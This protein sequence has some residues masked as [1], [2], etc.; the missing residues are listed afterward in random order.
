MQD[1]KTVGEAANEKKIV[2]PRKGV[3]FKSIPLISQELQEAINAIVID[4]GVPASMVSTASGQNQQEVNDFGGAKWWNKPLGYVAGAT[5][6]LENG[7]IVKSTVANNTIDPNVDMTGWEKLIRPVNM[8][9]VKDHGAIE[10]GVT[11]NASILQDYANII[12]TERKSYM[13]FP[14]YDESYLIDGTITFKYP[15]GI[16]GTKPASQTRNSVETGKKGN[17]LIG[18]NSDTVFDFGASLSKDDRGGYY[19]D[20]WTVKN[21]GFIQADGV[22]PRTKTCIKHTAATDG[23][24][25]FL[26]LREVSAM[27]VRHALHITNQNKSV[28]V[29]SMVVENCALSNNYIPLF[30]EGNVLGLRFVGNQCEQNYGGAIH[31]TF[32]SSVVIHDN[33]LE[34]QPNT[35]NI[36]VPPITGN[37]PKISIQ[38]NYFELNSGDYLINVNSNSSGGVI[39]VKNNYQ[40]LMQNVTDTLR[41]SGIYERFENHDFIPT[42]NL[43]LMKKAEG[44]ISPTNQFNIRVGGSN[45]DNASFYLTTKLDQ[46]KVDNSFSYATPS[47]PSLVVSTNQGDYRYIGMLASYQY[48]PINVEINDVVQ[49]D[50]AYVDHSATGGYGGAYA[51]VYT[52]DYSLALSQGTVFHERTQGDIEV[53]TMFFIVKKAT[54]ALRFRVENIGADTYL[55]GASAKIVGQRTVS[56]D[57]KISGLQQNAPKLLRATES[58]ISLTLD[59]ADGTVVPANGTHVINKN[60]AGIPVGAKVEVYCSYQNINLMF[61]GVCDTANQIKLVV[62]NLSGAAITL[63]ACTLTYKIF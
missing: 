14:M 13:H 45:R 17:I 8:V 3:P 22:T 33:M 39:E 4:E 26:M 61:Y 46:C 43:Q 19:A 63:P 53:V 21:I 58:A 44:K 24:D 52:N 38:G 34:G 18:A 35:I 10:D 28:Q 42:L 60:T 7:D 11:D 54:N 29:A 62:R 31:G 48:L 41:V 47:N 56:E 40:L 55:L 6:K 5:V 15:V 27:G 36:T 23:P 59:V 20:C 32:N 57:I 12:E 37:R 9:S 49:L 1:C 51:A 2:T 30:A 25:R 50:F 16:T